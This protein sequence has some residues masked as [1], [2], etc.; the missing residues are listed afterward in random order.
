M[1]WSH[2]VGQQ[3]KVLLIDDHKLMREGLKAVIRR[4]TGFT[5]VAEAGDAE[6]GLRAALR[7]KPDVVLLDISLPG[8]SGIHLLKELRSKLQ[9]ARILVV[10]MFSK[11]DVVREALEAGA[12]GYVTKDSS[13]ETLLQGLRSVSEGQF[14]V[15]SSVSRHLLLSRGEGNP[16]LRRLRNCENGLLS[17]REREVLHLIAEG[18]PP[19]KI[20]RKL[21]ISVK[22]VENHRANVLAKL[23]LETN[24]DL[25]KY[26]AR[27]GLIDLDT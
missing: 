12:M 18:A 16:R 21:F 4:E 9:T 2:K 25:V 10:S 24:A 17:L 15:D 14:Y 8:P 23:G 5:V 26:A 1:G 7:V 13:P 22:T 19:R 11:P 6:E 20:A 27:I 3:K